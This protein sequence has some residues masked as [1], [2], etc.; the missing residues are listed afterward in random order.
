LSSKQHVYHHI[1]FFGSVFLFFYVSANVVAGGI[2]FPV[3][4]CM[5]EFRAFVREFWT[6]VVSKVSCIFV[7]RIWPN[8]H[9]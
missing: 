6:N 3:C 7:D 2:M 5:Y 4:L 1:V 9:Q 8:F